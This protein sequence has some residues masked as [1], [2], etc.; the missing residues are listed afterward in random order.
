MNWFYV[1]AYRTCSAIDPF[2]SLKTLH[3]ASSSA[4]L[5]ILHLAISPQPLFMGPSCFL[6][7]LTNVI[8]EGI[9]FFL[10]LGRIPASFFRTTFTNFMHSHGFSYH[11]CVGGAQI[12]ISIPELFLAFH[13]YVSH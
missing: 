2:R 8:F 1:L 12:L 13:S 9:V 4:V 5:F 7:P 10:F 11:L 3:R 6:H